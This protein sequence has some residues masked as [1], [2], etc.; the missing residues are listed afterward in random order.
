P[1]LILADEP[2]ANV[3]RSNQQQIVD[4]IRRT[5]REEEVAL[6]LVSHSMEVAEQFER[7]DRLED[8]NR[9]GTAA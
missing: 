2:T 1:S 3:D 6:V 7:V 9:T 4:L 5:C 8:I